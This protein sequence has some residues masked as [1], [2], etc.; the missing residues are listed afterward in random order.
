MLH[1]SR[2]LIF[3][4]LIFLFWVAFNSPD[5]L[6]KEK[7]VA[8][9]P[10]Q[11][12][13]EPRLVGQR[14]LLLVRPKES[15]FLVQV[16]APQFPIYAYGDYLEISGNIYNLSESNFAQKNPNYFL[17]NK[18]YYEIKN[19]EIQVL[20]IEPGGIY[21]FYVDLR[22]SLISVRQNFVLAIKEALPEPQ[23]SLLAGI[24]FG[25]RGEIP[26]NLRDQ[27]TAVGLIHIIAL[28]GY[29]IT[30][31]AESIR[32]FFRKISK[33]FSFWGSLIAVWLF[34]FSTAFSP[35]VVRAAIMG[36][37]LLIA[38]HLGRRSS[39]LVAILLASVIMVAESPNIL[40]YDIGFQLSFAAVSGI[41]F[42]NPLITRYFE[43]FGKLFGEILATTFSAQIFTF[44][45]IGFYFERLSLV[46]FFSN[47]LV[48]PI[49]PFLMLIG[50]LGSLFGFFW[51]VLSGLV[52]QVAW[53]L[54]TY[55]I[56]IAEYFAAFD[57]SVIDFSVNFMEIVL[58]YFLLILAILILKK[59][60]QN[61]K[62]SL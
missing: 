5:F 35:S 62:R 47:L 61:E 52:F 1:P 6:P 33:R 14:Q 17:A 51:D 39:G 18:I 3:F 50:F 45:L 34:V 37:I 11:V 21:G 44:A 32:L 20:N 2:I 22:K 40:L 56:K 4:S 55:I 60:E 25:A 13:S 43:V 7:G 30:I 49:I 9:N 36:S 29:N 46:S 58:I 53:F 54:L 59:K 31:I 10:M 42:L 38:G 57:F 41:I 16:W 24:L 26:N 15:L 19:P 48:L 28:S 23:A 27:L 8:K 12:I